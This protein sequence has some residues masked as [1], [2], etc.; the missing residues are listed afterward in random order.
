VNPGMRRPSSDSQLHRWEGAA[1]A[2][3]S[4]RGG[5]LQSDPVLHAHAADAS[6]SCSSNAVASPGGGDDSDGDTATSAVR[7]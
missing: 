7:G 2:Y 1:E 3:S 5:P 4:A 6:S